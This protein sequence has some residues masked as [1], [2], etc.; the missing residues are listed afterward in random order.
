MLLIVSDENTD[1]IWMDLKLIPT[2]VDNTHKERSIKKKK[3]TY[4]L[5]TYQKYYNQIIV[6]FFLKGG[7]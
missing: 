4:S 5:M 3:K 2:V 6:T 7:R 1:F